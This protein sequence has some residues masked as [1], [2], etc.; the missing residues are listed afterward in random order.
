MTL[1]Q[2]PDP[3]SVSPG[4]TG[5]LA[6]FALVA[7]C[8][9]LFVS[10]AR[11]LRRMQYRADH[12]DRDDDGASATADDHRPADDHRSAGTDDGAPGNPPG[13]PDGDGAPHD[14]DARQGR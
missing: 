13:P 10:M 4:L 7:V 3:N 11:R 12:D 1:V 6:T 14:P 9:L 2:G 5:F 8:L